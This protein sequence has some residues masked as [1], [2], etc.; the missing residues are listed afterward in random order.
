MP[1]SQRVTLQPHHQ[2]PCPA[3]RELAVRVSGSPENAL[4]LHYELSGDIAQ[5]RVPAAVPAVETDGLWQHTCF[6][7]FAARV[8]FPQ[9]CEYNFS[10][11]GQWAGYAFGDYRVR[12]TTRSLPP[13]HVRLAR[14]RESLTLSV[15]L[16]A[17]AFH[18]LGDETADLCF[19]LS[20]VI[21]DASGYRSYW[22]L[23][24]AAG[25]PDF[26][27]RESFS[28]SLGVVA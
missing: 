25:Q 17:G 10:P 5:L 7:L 8:G 3:V 27:R 13:P 28:L 2:T 4:V 14:L 22:A 6:E 23:S 24:H 15:C 1:I 26:H 11:S 16:P 19:G 12:D 21:E 20:A 9:Y 18:A